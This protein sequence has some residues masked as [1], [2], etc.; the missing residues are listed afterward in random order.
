MHSFNEFEDSRVSL[1][2]LR[3]EPGHMPSDNSLLKEASTRLIILVVT[4]IQ[5]PKASGIHR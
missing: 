1:S 2:F 4:I 3:V 5:P